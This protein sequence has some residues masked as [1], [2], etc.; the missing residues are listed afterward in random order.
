MYFDLEEKIFFGKDYLLNRKLSSLEYSFVNS[1]SP[2]N[3]LSQP[4]VYETLF[5]QSQINS[6]SSYIGNLITDSIKNTNGLTTATLQVTQYGLNLSTGTAL[7]SD[8]Q[9]NATWG[10]VVTSVT[11]TANQVFTSS[12]TGAIT[13]SLPQNINIA[14]SPTFSNI[15]LTTPSYGQLLVGGGTGSLTSTPYSTTGASGTVVAWDSNLNISANNFLRVVTSTTGTGTITLSSTSSYY[16]LFKTGSGGTFTVVLPSGSTLPIGWSVNLNNNASGSCQVQTSGGANLLLLGSGTMCEFICTSNGSIVGTWDYHNSLSS[17][18]TCST[19]QLYHPPSINSPQLIG[20]LQ[21]PAQSNI[22]SVGTL[23]ALR[24]SGQIFGS[25]GTLA[26]PSYAFT[27]ATSSGMYLSAANT[28]SLVSNG[29]AGLTIDPS[30]GR[31]TCGYGLTVVGDTTTITTTNF[32]VGDNIGLLAM[33]NPADLIDIGVG[34]GYITGG[35]QRYGVFYRGYGSDTWYLKDGVTACGTRITDGSLANLAVGAIQL[36]TGASNNYILKSDA[37][38]N[39]TWAALSSLGVTSVQ[40]T[41][42]ILVNGSF[43]TPQTGTI[44]L[45]TAQSI[46]TTS[47]VVF[48]T[49]SLGGN[50]IYGR[51]QLGGGNSSGYLYGC[52]AKYD[53]GIHLGYNFY[54]N[55]TSNVITNSGG[56]TSRMSF[57]YGT[58]GAYI[59]AINTEPTTVGWYVNKSAQ[60]GIRKTPAYDFDV[61]A[62]QAVFSNSG[63]CNLYIKDTGGT[64]ATLLLVSYAGTN[65]I[66]TSGQLIFCDIGYAHTYITV[67]GSD[68]LTIGTASSTG[69]ITLNNN[70][71]SYTPKS[72]NY[73]EET[74]VSTTFFSNAGG[75]T[76]S[77][78]TITLTRIGRIVTMYIP[79][80]NVLMGAANDFITTFG[81]PI[82]TRFRPPNGTMFI[83]DIVSNNIPTAGIIW[84]TQYGNIQVYSNS[85]YGIFVGLTNNNGM[86]NSGFSATYNV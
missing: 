17:N 19:I 61:L 72:L 66:Q 27:G 26:G 77:S 22:T 81:A 16:Q 7:L 23:N 36:A 30:T 41:K 29:I 35:N 31:V 33:N 64:P 71:T 74:S 9:G 44:S 37:S 65:Y 79:I 48:G 47:S 62:S 4:L 73:Y 78:I 15:I 67:N 32:S 57:G 69:G 38:G 2:M 60:V 42:S 8:A 50:A 14:S 55:N 75:S 63:G 10:P 24:V 40:G 21:T 18:A 51:Y 70:T 86:I 54:N 5:Q 3:S 58:I 11:G 76:G 6:S 56:E 80:F 25:S 45:T 39:A 84:I 43:G 82:P 46:E 34:F 20:T 49:V 52:F 68:F 1:S 85:A 53:D 13:I 59:G 12:S 83:A 28:V